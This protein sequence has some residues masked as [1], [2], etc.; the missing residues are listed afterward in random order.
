[1]Q[2]QLRRTDPVPHAKCEP[3]HT[4]NDASDSNGPSLYAAAPPRYPTSES[5]AVELQPVAPVA[6]QQFAA[7]H[8]SLKFGSLDSG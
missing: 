6:A 1:M 2:A 3:L 8:D 4:T 5:A 7:L